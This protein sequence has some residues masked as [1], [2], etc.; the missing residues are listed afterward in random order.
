MIGFSTALVK[1]GAAA[2]T[3]SNIDDIAAQVDE[4]RNEFTAS[5]RLPDEQFAKY[6]GVAVNDNVA[7]SLNLV[8]DDSVRQLSRRPGETKP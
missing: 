2:T 3:Y 6:F 4:L 7:R 1:A 8:I 5:G